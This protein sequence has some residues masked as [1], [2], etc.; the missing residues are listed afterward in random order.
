MITEIAK[1]VDWSHSQKDGQNNLY[2]D[3]KLLAKHPELMGMLVE[4]RNL[5]EEV[6]VAAEQKTIAE[7]EAKHDELIIDYRRYKASYDAVKENDLSIR[8]SQMTAD[9][10]A[11]LASSRYEGWRYHVEE[12]NSEFETRSEKAG[13]IAKLEELKKAMDAAVLAESSVVAKLQQHQY[14]LAEAAEKVNNS[15]TAAAQCKRDLGVILGEKGNYSAT[16]GLAMD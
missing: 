15:A 14:W 1:I 6:A 16:T 12:S 7:L 9:N 5:Y 3:M 10:A 2:V 11:R 4:F 13:K 8:N